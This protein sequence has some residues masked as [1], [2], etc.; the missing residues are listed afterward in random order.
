MR[1]RN[2]FSYSK[3]TLLNDYTFTTNSTCPLITWSFGDGQFGSGPAVPHVYSSPGVYF[4]YYSAGDVNCCPLTSSFLTITV[5]AVA[6]FTPVVTCNT[7]CFTDASASLPSDPIDPSGYSWDFGDSQTSTQINPCHTYAL[8]GTYP[9]TLEITT[10]SGCKAKI[11]K[12]VTVN[13]PDVTATIAASAC[14]QPVNFLGSTTVANI[15][16]WSWDFGDGFGSNIQNPQHIYTVASC[17][18]FTVK[19]TVTDANG[20]TAVDSGMITVCPPPPPFNLI[21][22]SPGCGNVV[23]DA[24]SGYLT[25]QWFLKWNSNQ[26]GN[27]SNVY[28]HCNRKL[29]L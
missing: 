19:V 10:Q 16:S 15:T 5:P 20:C 26:R 27:K 12:F 28:C 13:G 25:Y 22:V 21:Y 3:W 29:L 24:G 7:V 18:T 8:A 1:C 23:I 2:S 14:N 11:I 4:V 9:V 17:T 6:D